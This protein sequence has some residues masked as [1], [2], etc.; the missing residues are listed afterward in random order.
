MAGCNPPF[1]PYQELA[2]ASSRAAEAE[3][4]AQRVESVGAASA[5]EVDALKKRLA[6]LQASSEATS[7]ARNEHFRRLV[8]RVLKLVSG[9][10]PVSCCSLLTASQHTLN[11]R[12]LQQYPTPTVYVSSKCVFVLLL[13]SF[14]RQRQ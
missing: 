13:H 14:T 10:R 9:P 3:A 8:V 1:S 2:A 12:R 7:K 4:A 5:K 11:L 6:E